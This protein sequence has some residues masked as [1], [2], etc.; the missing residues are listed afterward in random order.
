MRGIELTV[1]FFQYLMYNIRSAII[2][3]VVLIPA[4]IFYTSCACKTER[5]QDFGSTLFPFSFRF[6][7]FLALPFIFPLILLPGKPPGH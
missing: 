3:P 1:N 7:F 4:L 6:S 2:F 5:T